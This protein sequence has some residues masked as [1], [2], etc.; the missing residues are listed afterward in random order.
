MRSTFFG[1]ETARRGMFT[2]QTALN[3]LGNNVANASTPGYSRQRVNFETTQPFAP[4]GLNMP[5]LPGQ[6]GTGVQAGTIQRIRET[7]LDVQYRGETTKQ[8]FWDA[9]TDALTKM[10]EI[11]NEPTDNG[12]SKSFNLFWQSL[13]DLATSPTNSGARSVVRQR[14]MALAE[15]FHYVSAS[16]K[17]VQLDLRNQID[18]NT[19]QVNSLLTQ[20]NSVNLQIADVEP[21]GLLPNDLYDQRDKLVDQLSEYV[22]IKVST[23]PSGGNALS[24]AEGKYKIEMVNPD[25]SD[26]V[27][28]LDATNPNDPSMVK[29]F[30]VQYDDVATA[31]RV[32]TRL[33]AG[34]QVDG[35][36]VALKQGRLRGVIESYGYLDG[37]MDMTNPAAPLKVETGPFSSAA[38]PDWTTIAQ[39][40][41]TPEVTK[42]VY[43]SMLNQ[44]DELAYRFVT[45]FNRVHDAGWSFKEIDAG[46]Q[47][48]NSW[49]F[50]PLGPS[51]SPTYNDWLNAADRIKLS[52][53]IDNLDNIATAPD[54]GGTVPAKGN[55]QNA[56]NLSNS[57]NTMLAFST[58]TTSVE[59]YF[60]KMIGTLAV[61]SQE[62][63][64][65]RDNSEALQL[66][67][68]NR[69]Q[70]VSGVSLDEEMT[71]MVTFQHA[72]NASARVLTALD[73]VLDKIINGMGLVG[74]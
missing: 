28:I 27:L 21:N 47:T 1:I 54:V 70:S 2:Q 33:V 11:V 56:I 45:E 58:T 31:P 74:R 32:A 5:H 39:N 18:I 43:S 67:V 69:R 52:T 10:E 72:Y 13:Q 35:E 4:P 3:T 15:T 48:P 63:G 36:N 38:Q 62:A 26:P 66:A 24:I 65:L 6:M 34:I 20:I 42:G 7:F 44:L 60:Q 23:I 22:N 30:S 41:V 68:E 59:T 9:K 50:E 14:G 17:S 40:S 46:A 49:F 19:D 29:K 37:Y 53:N 71:N 12:L 16:L 61:E 55:G 64:R 73:E 25:G 8:S 51:V 57:K